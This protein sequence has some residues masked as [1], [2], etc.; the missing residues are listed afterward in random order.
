M[1]N[2]VAEILPM[3]PFPVRLINTSDRERNLPKGMIVGHALPHSLGIVA[4][5]DQEDFSSIKQESSKSR[6][7]A[8]QYAAMQNPPPLPDRPDYQFF[9]RL[10][11]RKTKR[12]GRV[13]FCTN[14]RLQLPHPLL[15]RLITFR[16]HSVSPS[17]LS[18]R[19]NS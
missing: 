18:I 2:G 11:E 15:S 14:V 5:A 4:V 1:A 12:L 6:T 7:E 9:A 8:E 16:A 17:S 10:R 19:G 13:Y 3:Q